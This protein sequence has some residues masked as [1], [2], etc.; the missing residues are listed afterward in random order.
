MS[1]VTAYLLQEFEKLPFDQQREFSE[2][3]LHRATQFDYDAP[4]D[5]ELIAAAREVF[6]M[7][8]REEDDAKSR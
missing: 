6:S 7:L 8:D 1:T 4:S 5:E 3:I 2:V